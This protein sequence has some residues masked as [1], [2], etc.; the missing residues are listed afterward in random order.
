MIKRAHIRQFLA[1]VDAGSFTQAAQQIRVT[2]PALSTGVA[3]LERLVGA[4]L[5]IRNRR[6]IRLTEAGGRFLPIAREL[7]RAFRAADG[8]GRD[9]TATAPLLRI[10]AIRSAPGEFLQRI[11]AEFARS[12]SIEIVEG[13]DSELRTALA[14]GRI[15]IALVP[16]K[17][18]EGEGEALA[19]YEEPLV[20]LVPQDH[21]LAS[22]GEVSPEKLAPETMI[23]RRSCEFLD[24]TS[25]FF[26]RHGVRP[27]FSLRSDSDDRCIRMV[28][29]GI[30]ITT[31]PLSLAGED[32]VALRVTGY[33]FRRELGLLFASDWSGLPDIARRLEAPLKAIDAIAR[34]WQRARVAMIA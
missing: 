7:E 6:K 26:T 1:V 27:R 15:Q 8:F 24:A 20:M 25:R 13:S 30:G 28:A 19:L 22:R 12:F 34:D 18:G 11:V 33:D 16:L 14:S 5:F 21:P 29:A 9:E 3:E 2:Q 10:G 17:A 23:A 4:Q 31:A 32:T